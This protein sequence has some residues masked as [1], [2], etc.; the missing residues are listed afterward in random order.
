MILA[1]L[2]NHIAQEGTVSRKDLAKKFA[3]SEDGVDAMLS[4]WVKKGQV[5]RMIDTNEAQ[6]ITRVRY[7]LNQMNQL[8]MTVTM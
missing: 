4:V 3:L 1:D 6:F 2:K 7:S 5:T 8:S